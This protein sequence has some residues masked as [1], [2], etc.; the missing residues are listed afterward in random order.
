M[1]KMY[2][3]PELQIVFLDRCD[4]VTDSDP[5]GPIDDDSIGDSGI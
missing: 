2:H 5:L 4:I 3:N 1:K